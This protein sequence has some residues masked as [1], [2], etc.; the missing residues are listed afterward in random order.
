MLPVTGMPGLLPVTAMPGL[1]P[2]ASEARR[3]RSERRSREPV[4]VEPEV[5]EANV[6]KTVVV[7]GI[8]SPGGRDLNGRVGVIQRWLAE[9]GRYQ[10]YLPGAPGVLH[11]GPNGS[12]M[13]A[14]RPKNIG[15]LEGDESSPT[16]PSCWPNSCFARDRVVDF[17]WPGVCHGPTSA[18]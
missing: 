3:Q 15:K 10:L 17:V 12:R 9:Q 16:S 6:G 13:L 11:V 18:Q 2:V 5:P 14:L 7:R 8:L 4:N 1:L